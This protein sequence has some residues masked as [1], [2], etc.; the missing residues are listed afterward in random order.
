MTAYSALSKHYDAFNECVDYPRWA[1]YLKRH[2]QKAAIPVHTVLDLACGT[3]TLC[4]LLAADGYEVI[5]TDSSADMLSAAAAKTQGMDNAPIYIQ[6]DMTR[7]DL[8]GTVDAAVCCLDSIN[9]LTRPKDVIK[10]FSLVRLFL[11]PG[12][13]FIFDINTSYK[14]SSLDGQSFINETEDAFC[15][16]SAFYSVKKRMASFVMDIFQAQDGLWQRTSEE[17]RERA[18]EPEEIEQFLREAG[19]S[20]IQAFGHLNMRAPGPEEQR[21]FFRCM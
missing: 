2:F 4:V 5:G 19:F 11:N 13:V 17:H 3:G 12:G 16:W 6:Q 9:Y 18:Y 1:D 15:A 21:I 7:L 20:Q 10:T 8:Y 14:L